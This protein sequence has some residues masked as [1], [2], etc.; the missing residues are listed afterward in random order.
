MIIY[1]DLSAAIEIKYTS[2]KPT[3]VLPRRQTGR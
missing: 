3:I 2:H 1:N